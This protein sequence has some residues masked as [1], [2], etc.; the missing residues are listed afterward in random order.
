MTQ[1]RPQSA[2]E[3]IDLAQADDLRDVVHRAVA[4]LAQGGVIALPTETAYG[5]AASALKSEAVGRLRRL[6]QHWAGQPQPQP[7]PLGIKGSDEVADWVPEVSPEGRRICRRAWPG[8]VTL[9]FRGDVQRGLARALPAGVRQAVVPGDTIGLR[10]PAHPV[11]REVLRLIPGPIVLT[12]AP[13]RGNPEAMGPEALSSL[14]EIDMVLDNGPSQTTGRPTVVQ[15][16]D[17]TWSVLRPGAVSHDELVRMAGTMILFVCTGNTCRSPM[18]EALCKKLLA[19]RLRCEQSA[20]EANG[21]VVLSAGVAAI[22]GMPA[23]ANAVEVVHALGGTLRKHQSRR[24][25]PELVQHADMIVTMTRDHYDVLV[26]HVP[27]AADRTRL[28]HAE[29]DDI[30]DPVGLDRDTYKRTAR[31]IEK[32]LTQMLDDLGL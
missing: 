2:P 18:A 5:L 7:L 19:E 30:D 12:G 13:A 6:K 14:S 3:R 11:V 10:S 8:P 29:G 28:L 23:A 4:C 32:H 17:S 22:D 15:V 20:L 9:V 1:P 21:Y 24:L 27:E 25:T 26:T 16:D 31:E